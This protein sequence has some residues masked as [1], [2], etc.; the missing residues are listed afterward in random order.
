MRRGSRSGSP[1]ARPNFCDANKNAISGSGCIE[2]LDAFNNSPDTGFDQTPEPFDRPGPAQVGE[3]QAA[4][5]N[6]TSNYDCE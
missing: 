4:R 6:G 3:C 2:A 1:T 5:G